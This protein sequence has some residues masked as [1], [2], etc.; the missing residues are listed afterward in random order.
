MDRHRHTRLTLSLQL[1]IYLAVPTCARHK[2]ATTTF[3]A[4]LLASATGARSLSLCP[5]PGTVFLGWSDS[6]SSLPP[7]S[8]VWRL[9][10]S[11]AF[12]VSPDWRTV[13]YIKRFRIRVRCHPLLFCSYCFPI[14]RS[15]SNSFIV[16]GGS[17]SKIKFYR[18]WFSPGRWLSSQHAILSLLRR[19]WM[20]TRGV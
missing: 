1:L 19:M 18:R 14:V 4:H 15:P 17:R 16:L 11:R 9:S 6:S 2:M 7:S 13:T 10:C 8:V 20:Q 5:T 12:D 3:H